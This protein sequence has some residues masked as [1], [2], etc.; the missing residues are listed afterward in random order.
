MIVGKGEKKMLRVQKSTGVVTSTANDHPT[1]NSKGRVELCLSTN[2]ETATPVF[3]FSEYGNYGRL[4]WNTEV[5]LTRAEV[6]QMVR[7]AQEWLNGQVEETLRVQPAVV[8]QRDVEVTP[9]EKETFEL[10]NGNR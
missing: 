9:E 6:E 1:A 10:V 2:P 4:R 5:Q 8:P 7:S 3:N